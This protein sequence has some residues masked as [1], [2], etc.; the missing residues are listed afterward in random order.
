MLDLLQHE[1]KDWAAKAAL[2]SS[3]RAVP[4]KRQG[5][6]IEGRPVPAKNEADAEKGSQRLAKAA[7]PHMEYWTSSMVVWSQAGSQRLA[8]AACLTEFPAPT[9]ACKHDSIRP[10]LAKAARKQ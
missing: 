6:Y 1:N 10:L 8:K 5:T 2:A 3:D 9:I 4:A 7:S